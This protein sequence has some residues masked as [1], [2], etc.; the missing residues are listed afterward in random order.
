MRKAIN[1]TP[2]FP[3]SNGETYG[4][5]AGAHIKTFRLGRHFFALYYC[6]IWGVL[7]GVEGV[8]RTSDLAVRNLWERMS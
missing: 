7:L 2:G 5:T 4:S 8:G 6:A 1:F 3:R